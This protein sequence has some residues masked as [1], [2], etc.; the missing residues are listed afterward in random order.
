MIRRITRSSHE[1]LFTCPRRYY[2]GYEY[3]GTGLDEALP[4][5]RLQIGLAVHEGL[6]ESM[7]LLRES[8]DGSTVVPVTHAET[9]FKAFE[10][11]TKPH[12]EAWAEDPRWLTAL[13]EG[14]LLAYA[15]VYGWHKAKF[16]AFAR[17]FEVLQV[18]QELET[19]LG[20]DVVLQSRL[21]VLVRERATSDVW[22]IN[23]KTS[24][25][26]DPL[27]LHDQFRNDPQM[28]AEALAAEYALKEP[29]LGTIPIVLF[30]GALRNWRHS[31]PLLYCYG[32]DGVWKFSYTRGWAC[33]RADQRADLAQSGAQG[34]LRAWIDSLPAE[35]VAAGF[36]DVDPVMKINEVVEERLAGWV[37][38]ENATRHV[39]LRGTEADKLLHFGA[40]DGYWCQWCPFVGPCKEGGSLE[41]LV[42]EGRLVARV[43]HHSQER[44]GEE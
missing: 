30:K 27:K 7:R 38:R 34:G 33:V 23:W 36:I 1:A 22:V 39:L 2:L 13:D 10:R 35:T 6:E 16:A 40:R 9:A 15:L 31:T 32:K 4:G 21:D 44:K 25:K 37:Y 12:R 17:R 18:E 8:P 29:V 28:W 3:G 41:A 24:D 11:L 20:S 42:A 43:D 14:A 5:L 26:N 19:P